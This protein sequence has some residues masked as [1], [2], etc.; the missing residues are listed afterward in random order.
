M[1][2][3]TGRVRTRLILVGCAVALAAVLWIL[4][5][6]QAGPARAHAPTVSHE[7]VAHL[8]PPSPEP[9]TPPERPA[10]EALPELPRWFLPARIRGRVVRRGEGVAGAVVTSV[11]MFGFE[12]HR[13]GLQAESPRVL[14]GPDGRFEIVD[15]RFPYAYVAAYA[16]GAFGVARMVHGGSNG[17]VEIEID[18]LRYER[19]RFVDEAGQP[20]NVTG[21]AGLAG[22]LPD[23]VSEMVGP[24]RTVRVSEELFWLLIGLEREVAANEVLAIGSGQVSKVMQGDK[25]LFP[26]ERTL[27]VPGFKPARFTPRGRPM[28]DWPRATTIVLRADGSVAPTNVRRCRFVLPDLDYPQPWRAD[29]LHPEIEIVFG[30]KLENGGYAMRF[31]RETTTDW[32]LTDW[33]AGAEFAWLHFDV[34]PADKFAVPCDMQPRDGVTEISPAYPRLAFVDVHFPVGHLD[35]VLWNGWANIQD[36]KSDLAGVFV[37]AFVPAGHTMG[38]IVRPGHFRIGPVLPGRYRLKIGV[39]QAAGPLKEWEFELDVEGGHS[40]FD[41]R[42]ES[43]ARMTRGR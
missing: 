15:D 20:V 28:S 9:A 3:D 34:M 26:A 2:P 5:R 39:P 27:L 36:G 21:H 4:F 18:S 12:R 24:R 1:E 7:P 38:W 23:P 37:P 41:I 33:E 22:L 6:E 16:D 14:T 10:P 31:V 40:R 17:E 42:S 11:P 19:Y 25:V 13:W 8:A 43:D 30:R 35:G 32:I 29:G